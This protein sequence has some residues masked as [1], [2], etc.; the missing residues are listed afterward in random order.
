[1][2]FIAQDFQPVCIPVSIARHGLRVRTYNTRFARFSSKIHNNLGIDSAGTRSKLARWV[3]MLDHW[4]QHNIEYLQG[5]IT[6]R[7]FP[8]I[9]VGYR[10][11]IAERNESYYVESVSHSW[12]YPEPLT[13]TMALSRGQRNDPYPVYIHPDTAAFHGDR[14]AMSRLARFFKQVDPEAVY[15][16]LSNLETIDHTDVEDGNITDNIDAWRAEWAGNEQGYTI[17][18]ESGTA[19]T[20]LNRIRELEK[21]D[22]AE[23]LMSELLKLSRN[24]LSKDALKL[25]KMMEESGGSSG[26]GIKVP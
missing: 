8:E 26:K 11:D 2:K 22:D 12:Q 4:Y 1:M 9:R 17:S 24:R 16:S 6:T 15:R 14:M 20:L 23:K 7:A 19:G 25:G 18:N 13:T 3:V 5:T 21:G 10:L